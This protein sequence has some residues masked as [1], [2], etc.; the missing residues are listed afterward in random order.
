MKPILL[1]LLGLLLCC[2][3]E[4]SHIA[5]ADI[6]YEY[7]G[8]PNNTYKLTL[9]LLKACE[10]GGVQLQPGESIVISSSCTTT[11]TVYATNVSTDTL[12]S[13]CAMPNSCSVPTALMPGFIRKVYTVNVDL[14][15]A[16]ADYKFEWS[17][18]CRNAGIVNLSNPS[19]LN[20]YV[21]ATMNNLSSLNTNVWFPN[22]SP[23]MIATGTMNSIPM[24]MVD[25]ENDSIVVTSI[26]PMT[27]ASTNA[28]WQ[29]GF[30]MSNPLGAGSTLTYDVVNQVIQVQTS[31]MGKFALAMRVD[32]YRAG[33]LVG[34][35]MRDFTIVALNA[36]AAQTVPM[37]ASSSVMH[38]VTCPGQSHSISVTF[39][40]ATVT[41]SVFLNIATPTMTGWTFTSSSTSA[42][43]TATA[44]ISWTT[45]GIMNPANLPQFY[46]TVQAT[47][48]SCPM[49]SFG[50]Y[51]IVV[52]TA[53]CV[54]DSVWPGD[55]N[56]DYTVNVYDPLAIAVA[57]N[58]VG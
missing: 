57:H 21:K 30:T 32:E 3:L 28:A 51:A 19:G 58:Y 16:C 23:F 39:N 14:P 9:T 13:Y 53:Q 52:Q 7:L 47:D 15:L 37:P 41:D 48:N 4:A 42:P 6:R 8:G 55:A 31:Q 40:D 54:A 25:A 18:C 45:P 49:T 44:T 38:Y 22:P 5:S 2:R 1:T 11:D 24:H 43:G 50:Q 35:S 26:Q 17:N 10:P 36:S 20:T 33:T 56:G 12:G 46:F 27:D 29:T 34:S